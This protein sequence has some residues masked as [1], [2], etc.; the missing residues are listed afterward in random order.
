MEWLREQYGAWRDENIR[1]QEGQFTEA[2]KNLNLVNEAVSEVEKDVD[3]VN[4]QIR[5]TQERVTSINSE[6]SELEGKLQYAYE[7]SKYFS[8]SN[9]GTF[10]LRCIII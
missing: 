5:E 6:I 8:E 4:N 1:W 7:Y 9:G 2:E 3:M 10:R